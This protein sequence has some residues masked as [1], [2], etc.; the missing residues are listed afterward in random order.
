[1]ENIKLRREAHQF[2]DS[3]FNEFEKPRRNKP[4]KPVRIVSQI[5]KSRS[6]KTTFFDLNLQ[7][8]NGAEV[9]VHLILKGKKS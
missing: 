6:G 7:G 5:K 8:S 1:M 2:L 3:F 9:I 4:N